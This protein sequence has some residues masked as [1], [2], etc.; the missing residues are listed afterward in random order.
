MDEMKMLFEKIGSNLE[1]INVN[2]VFGQPQKLGERVV[3]PVA[4]IAWGFG[5]GMGMCGP[6][7]C[8]CAQSGDEAPCCGASKDEAE[9]CCEH[10]ESCECKCHDAGCEC[11]CHG[12]GMGSGGGGGAGGR[13]RPIAY[14]EVGPEGTRVEPIVDQQKITFA[15]MLLGAW[16][17]A[18]VGLVLKTLFHAL[19][20]RR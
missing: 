12:E 6:G 20:P 16:T 4:E 19:T 3:I 9:A 11:E 8:C 1:K 13:A 18:W 2:A 15:G 10:D 5:A 14:I 7:S 17:I